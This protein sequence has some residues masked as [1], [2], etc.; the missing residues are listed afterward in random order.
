MQ[1]SIF[2]EKYPIFE[3]RLPK[4]DCQYTTCADIIQH[5]SDSVIQHPMAKLIAHF[6]HLA[7]TQSIDGD[8][9]PDIL[10]AQH[11]IFCFGMKLPNASVMAVRPRSIGVVEL[12][13]AFVIN[14]MEPPMPVATQAMIGWVKALQK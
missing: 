6:D 8:I 2:M 1:T 14:F 12:A 7:H 9:N 11:I 3:L 13:D 5:L 4:S 10:S